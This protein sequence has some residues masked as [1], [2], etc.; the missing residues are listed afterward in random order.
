[1]VNQLIRRNV[2]IYLLYKKTLNIIKSNY[3]TYIMLI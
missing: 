1:M 2:M 3:L